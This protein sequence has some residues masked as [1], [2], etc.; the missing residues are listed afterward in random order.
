MH[1]S[2]GRRSPQSQAC[3]DLPESH[4]RQSPSPSGNH[5]APITKFD[6]PHFSISPANRRHRPV[7]AHGPLAHPALSMGQPP[8]RQD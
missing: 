5:P 2:K 4:T 8:P 6:R 3:L 7:F 1:T